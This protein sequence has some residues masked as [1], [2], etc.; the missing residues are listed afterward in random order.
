MSTE[1]AVVVSPNAT[2]SSTNGD[3]IEPSNNETS[4]SAMIDPQLPL[5]TPPT[6]PTTA[7][8]SVATNYKYGSINDDSE[9]EVDK[10]DAVI[11]RKKVKANEESENE[12]TE[13]ELAAQSRA[14]PSIQRA[15]DDNSANLT[16]TEATN[17]LV[18]GSGTSADNVA[19]NETLADEASK[20]ASEFESLLFS[21]RRTSARSRL[22][23]LISCLK[24]L[25][26][27]LE[28]RD[29]VRDILSKISPETRTNTQSSL[30]IVASADTKTNP[31]NSTSTNSRK[32]S[33]PDELSTPTTSQTEQPPQA[34]IAKNA[35]PKV[36]PTPIF[37]DGLESKVVVACPNPILPLPES[38]HP[39]SNPPV[40]K[41]RSEWV[42]F[43]QK[44]SGIHCPDF[45]VTNRCPL[46]RNCPRRHV[47]TPLKP[48]THPMTKEIVSARRRKKSTREDN[49]PWF[50]KSDL[51]KAYDKYR[52]VTLTKESFSDKIKPDAL[53]VAYYTCSFTCPVDDIV[54]YAQPFPG[55]SFVNGNKSSQGIW[56]YLNMKDAKEAL[57]TLVIR[58]LQDRKIIPQS[59]EPELTNDDEVLALNKNAS[60]KA[61]ALA[62]SASAKASIIAAPVVKKKS[63]LPSVL[64]DIKPWNWAELNYEVRC[65]LFNQP[66]G[67]PL[68]NLCKH[69]HVHYP[70]NVITE[71]FPPKGALPLA[72]K[73]HLMVQIHDPFFQTNQR[74]SHVSSSVFHVKTLIDNRNQIWYTAAWICPHEKTIFYAAGGPTGR[75]NSQNFVLYPSVEEAKLAVTGVVLNSFYSR[76]MIGAW[77]NG[78]ITV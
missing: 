66:Q 25:S 51:E 64:P 40:L 42:Q 7:P 26:A 15:T 23:K 4:I 49:L 6:K 56:W 67:C 62:R 12:P 9:D 41:Q 78:Y 75:S 2:Q 20:D 31:E 33:R 53:N 38:L 32:R 73:Q 10:K 77:A 69:A 47:Y 34:K 43:H 71:R 5:T 74:R 18:N 28:R 13:V 68:G 17:G 44:G 54:Y 55:D 36:S 39:K 76:G 11:H 22:L 21:V 63:V 16:C 48:N 65:P 27:K 14:D 37:I 52:N 70:K 35:V 3:T 19:E 58:D 30:T 59:F 72:Y 60:A 1:N 24:Q 8:M 46:G 29:E 57:A 50:Q 61:M 45:K